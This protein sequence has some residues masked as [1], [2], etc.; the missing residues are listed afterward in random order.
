[1]TPRREEIEH[2]SQHLCY[3]KRFFI[4]V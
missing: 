3:C 4:Q 2:S 1:M